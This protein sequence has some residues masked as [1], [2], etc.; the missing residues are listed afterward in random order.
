MIA[1]MIAHAPTRE[2]A[3]DKL[4][5]ARDRTVIVGPRSHGGLLAALC[6]AE[7]FRAGRF[8]TS[9]IARNI[10]GL[11]AG[12]QEIDNAAVARGAAHLMER[13]RQRLEAR[14]GPETPLSPWDIADAFQLS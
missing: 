9:F 8:D 11:L 3:L 1:K 2:A 12:P 13:E 4:A 5:A 7:D 10:A 6:R 14:R